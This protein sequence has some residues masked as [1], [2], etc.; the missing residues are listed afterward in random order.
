M[1]HRTYVCPN[2]AR[3]NG[4]NCPTKTVNAEQ[5]EFAIKSMLT[6]ILNAH[7]AYSNFSE[8]AFDVL[9]SEIQE[10]IE[11]LTERARDLYVTA[12][13]YLKNAEFFP[14]RLGAQRMTYWAIDMYNT[15]ANKLTE[16]KQ[17]KEQI[18][19][20]QTLMSN[21]QSKVT[22]LSV[23]EIFYSDEVARALCQ[24]FI[25]RIDI[26]E[27]NDDIEIAFNTEIYYNLG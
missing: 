27:K 2:H 1:K 19:I 17:L 11:E 26:D 5:L 8:K 25:E 24:I 21:Y 4:K 20:I 23:D 18:P 6:D 15:R 22:A 14:F 7:L 9:L 3:K 10:R 13:R 16:R 12:E